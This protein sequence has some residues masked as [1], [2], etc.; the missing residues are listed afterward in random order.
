MRRLTHLGRP[1]GEAGGAAL[2]ERVEGLQVGRDADGGLH[3]VA[4]ALDVHVAHR[5]Q[6][7]GG[8]GAADVVFA[9]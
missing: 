9:P 1:G 4:V 5:R 6:R 3:D 7:G 2:Q 8:G